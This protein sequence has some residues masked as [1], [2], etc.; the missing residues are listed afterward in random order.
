MKI[1]SL[2]LLLCI[3]FPVQAVF[4]ETGCS[5]YYASAEITYHGSG[6]GGEPPADVAC[7][8]NGGFPAT[9]YKTLNGFTYWAT[10]NCSPATD[11]DCDGIRDETDLCTAD[12]VQN[13]S[14]TGVDCGGGC[15]ACPTEPESCGNGIADLDIGET[16]TDCGGE[17]SS[18]CS[19]VCGEG[20]EL[21]LVVGVGDRCFRSVP[22]DTSGNCPP[23]Y[24]SMLNGD[25][26]A[27]YVP[28]YS[29][30]EVPP[31]PETVSTPPAVVS[32]WET[33]AESSTTS[34]SSSSTVNGTTT[35]TITTTQPNGDSSTTTSTTPPPG[36]DEQ[37]A[38]CAENPDSPICVKSSFGGS[39]GAFS[40][41]GDAVQCAMA[42]EQHNRN[43]TLFETET[44]IS[45]LGNQVVAG[46]DPQSSSMPWAAGQ[47]Q[48]QDLSNV[49]SQQ[50][51]LS[52]GGMAD[53]TVTVAGQSFSIPFSKA[54][55]VL[56]IMGAIVVTFSLIA[57]A[58]IVGVF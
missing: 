43:C 3:F 7:A 1:L 34:S 53:K 35:T 49:I 28:A 55:Q 50:R 52:S 22:Q 58:R 10:W 41:D 18:P 47:V 30:P 14:E 31:D 6:T 51:F 8:G 25:C 42:R 45:Q 57:A 56:Q 13:G 36:E 2:F 4:A 23:G 33:Y 40:C 15:P 46:N 20:D 5:T 16:G 11:N 44:A 24:T 39:C 54:N 38:F 19:P 17:C 12:G 29:K 37:D 48:S 26:Q 27:T 21:G 9:G 32:L